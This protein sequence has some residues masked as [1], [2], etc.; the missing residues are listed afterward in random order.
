MKVRRWDQIQLTFTCLMS[1]V[2]TLEKGV[3][4]VKNGNTR[5]TLLTSLRCFYCYLLTYLTPFHSVSIVDF[6]QVN[7]TWE[8]FLRP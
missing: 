1:T 5:T 4:Y 3:K 8:V 2:R 6:E 7:V